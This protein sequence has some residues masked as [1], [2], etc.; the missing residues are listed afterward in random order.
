LG[1]LTFA[2]I[3]FIVGILRLV[4]FEGLGLSKITKRC[5]IALHILGSLSFSVTLSL[6]GLEA[7]QN[8]KVMILGF[9]I[10]S[11]LILFPIQ[12]YIGIKRKILK[13]VRD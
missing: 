12:I 8:H 1:L 6:V 5:I 11:I 10:I 13:Q 4:E 2:T 3:F 7:H 9:F